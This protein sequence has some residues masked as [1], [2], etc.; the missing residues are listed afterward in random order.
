VAQLYLPALGSI[1]VTFYNSQGYGGGILTRLHTELQWSNTE[2]ECMECKIAN[3]IGTNQNKFR[4]N[5]KKSQLAAKLSEVVCLEIRNLF[6]PTIFH[7]R[8]CVDLILAV[9][10]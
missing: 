5:K 2:I 8:S 9:R 6:L 4:V 1:Y 7:N 10:I 3:E